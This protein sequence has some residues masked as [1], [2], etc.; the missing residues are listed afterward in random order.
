MQ[1]MVA[2]VKQWK[3]E[4]EMMDGWGAHYEAKAARKCAT[5]L[6]TAILE[7]QLEALTLKQAELESGYSC[8]ALQQ[9]VA[10]G[11]IQNAGEKNKPR[12]HRCDLPKKAGRRSL[13]IVR[14]E[15][16]LVDLVLATG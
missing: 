1:V 13:E 7:W 16:D 10:D 4:A 15:S 12:I 2:L 3:S 6:Q 14:S 11:E 8:S 5:E 9:M